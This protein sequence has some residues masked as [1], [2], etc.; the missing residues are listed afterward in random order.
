MTRGGNDG[1][2]KSIQASLRL[3][4]VAVKWEMTFYLYTAERFSEAARRRES[5][6]HRPADKVVGNRGSTG[7][8]PAFHTVSWSLE[9]TRC[10]K[11]HIN[12]LR[13]L[14]RIGT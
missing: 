8:K 1:R 11:L 2:S 10:I 5:T 9:V 12:K 13:K 4:R 7:L 14:T 3:Y 6:A